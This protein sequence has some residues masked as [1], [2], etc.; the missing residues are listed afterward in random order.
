[1]P[2]YGSV[3]PREPCVN[4]SLCMQVHASK[5][6]HATP[7]ATC[8]LPNAQREAL[9]AREAELEAAAE[10]QRSALGRR[11]AA[12]AA[13]EADLAQR[14]AALDSLQGGLDRRNV[15]QVR[16]AHTRMHD[17]APSCLPSTASSMSRPGPVRP[18]PCVAYTQS[19]M[20]ARHPQPQLSATDVSSNKK[21]NHWAVYMQ[22]HALCTQRI[23]CPTR[24]FPIPCIS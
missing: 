23:P 10:T 5:L 14:T 24:S 18:P 8:L 22:T 4:S 21:N 1:M 11:E 6:L 19:C 13:A 12:L 2:R 17:C 15:Q 7:P 16:R 9:V 3:D 20:H